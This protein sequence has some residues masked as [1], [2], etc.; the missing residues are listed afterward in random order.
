MVQNVAQQQE[1]MYHHQLQSMLSMN[2]PSVTSIEQLAVVH[3][4][5]PLDHLQDHALRPPPIQ[6]H[7]LRQHSDELIV[8]GHAVI[9][10]ALLR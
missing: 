7:L 6:N 10:A 8:A 4:C 2:L 9:F 3:H 5:L 1:M